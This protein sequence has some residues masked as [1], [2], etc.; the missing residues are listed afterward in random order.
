M[1]VCRVMGYVYIVGDTNSNAANGGGFKTGY[2]ATYANCQSSTG[3]VLASLD[4]CTI[5]EGDDGRI[6]IGYLGGF[7]GVPTGTLVNIDFDDTYTD[8]RSDSGQHG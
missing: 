2:N 1:W 7:T 8:Q 3:G 6:R 5:T 4:N